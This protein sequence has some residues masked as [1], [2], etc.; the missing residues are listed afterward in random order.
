MKRIKARHGKIVCV[1][2]PVVDPH[3][4]RQVPERNHPARLCP[5]L[6]DRQRPADP[7]HRA[8]PVR[9]VAGSRPGARRGRSRRPP[10]SSARPSISCAPPDRFA[11]AVEQGI[12]TGGVMYECVRNK[13]A[14]R[15]GRIHPRR[16]AAARYADG[17]DRRLSRLCRGHPG[18]GHD[19]DALLDAARHRHGQ[20]DPRRRTAGLHRH[21]ARRS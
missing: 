8:E 19:P 20:H 13:R 3:R 18:R 12:I 6:A 17:P 5:G 11:Q 16:R 21:H 1:A 7:R 2:G 9:H 15:P 4:R 14:L 10:A